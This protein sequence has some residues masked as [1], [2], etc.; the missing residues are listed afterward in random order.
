M[1][2]EEEKKFAWKQ[3]FET[4][5]GNILETAVRVYAICLLGAALLVSAPSY[6]A[7]VTEA[8]YVE[9]LNR[10]FIGVPN[11]LTLPPAFPAP[12][13]SPDA[14]Y[15]EQTTHLDAANSVE[16]PKNH[17][18]ENGGAETSVGVRS[19]VDQSLVPAMQTTREGYRSSPN[20]G[21]TGRQR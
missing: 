9:H 14:G 20:E 7:E 15:C 3:I 11:Q 12:V 21:R 8:P 6:G 10:V 18:G 1:R 16:I 4:K 2:Q 5:A 13:D 19:A 17:S